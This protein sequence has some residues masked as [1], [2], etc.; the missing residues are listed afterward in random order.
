MVMV[1]HICLKLADVG[2]LQM[3]VFRRCGS[4]AD[5]WGCIQTPILGVAPTRNRHP[6]ARPPGRAK[7]RDL[8]FGPFHEG[9]TVPIPSELETGNQTHPSTFPLV[10]LQFPL[11]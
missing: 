11:F 6:E 8:Q 1:P 9:Q 4:F 3:W 7:S 2:V 5:L 10:T